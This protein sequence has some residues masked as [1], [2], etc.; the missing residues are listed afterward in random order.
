ML[1][2]LTASCAITFQSDL[3]KE[4]LRKY[5]Q[6]PS[7]F[8]TL[9]NGAL[10]HYRDQGNPDGPVLLLI[11]G[12]LDS[13]QGWEPWAKILG[14]KYRIVTVDLPGHGLTG[15]IPSDIYTRASMVDF[16][17]EFIAQLRLDKFTIAG[18]SMGGGV[19][20]LYTLE[21]PDRVEGL[22]LLAS[23][24]ITED[25]L[26]EAAAKVGSNSSTAFP[27]SSGDISNKLSF[28]DK[29]YARLWSRKYLAEGLKTVVADDSLVTP[30][31]VQRFNDILLHKGNR[32]AQVLLARHYYAG[33]ASRRPRAPAGRKLRRQHCCYGAIKM[34]WLR[35]MPLNAL[36]PA[37][38]TAP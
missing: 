34:S 3:P 8:M 9:P 15:R 18:N 22:I 27:G 38:P 21:N 4:K 35:W 12:G 20:T 7:Q 13:L 14:D 23:G 25:S 5:W 10:A 36:T 17:E 1:I 31:F 28:T 29:L 6:T 26:K 11:H 19:S 24:G 30:E 16:L 32:Q 33:D 37:L 2:V